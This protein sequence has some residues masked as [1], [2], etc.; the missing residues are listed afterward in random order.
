M[1]NTINFDAPKLKV[2]RK[3]SYCVCHKTRPQG[4]PFKLASF[5]HQTDSRFSTH[6]CTLVS[7]RLL[8]NRAHDVLVKHDGKTR[9]VKGRQLTEG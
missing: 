8:A 6:Q 7:H 4:S 9:R 3:L 1:Y 2:T 5:W